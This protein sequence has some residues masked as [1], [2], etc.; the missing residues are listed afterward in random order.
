MTPGAYRRGAHRAVEPV[1]ARDGPVLRL[2]LDRPEQRNA[3]DDAMV[4]A[5]IAAFD[6][7]GRDDSVRAIVVARAVATTSAG[8]STSWPATPAARPRPSAGTIQRRLPGQAHRLIPLVLSVQVP[9]VCAVTG[10]AA[11][12]GFQLALAA[13][14]T[15]AAEDARFWEPFSARGFTPDSGATWLLPRLVG[16][17]RAREH[18]DARA[19]ALGDRGTAWGIVHRAVPPP[20]RPARSAELLSTLVDGPTVALGLTKWL[21]HAGSSA[22]LDEQLR[23]EGFALELSSRSE[24]FREG[25]AAF[26]GSDAPLPRFGGPLMGA[27]QRVV[28][29]SG[30]RDTRRQAGPQD[31]RVGATPRAG[32]LAGGGGRRG[33]GGDPLGA[34][35]RR[36]RGLVPGVRWFRSG[37]RHLAPRVRRARPDPRRG[38]GGGGRVVGLQPGPPQ[39][40]RAQPGRPGPL[41][42]RHRG[43][44]A[45]LPPAAGAQRGAVVPAVQRARRRVGPGLPGHPGRTGG[46]RL[47]GERAEGV[48]HLGP[49]LRVRRAAGPHGSRC[50]QTPGDHLLPAG[51]GPARGGGATAAPH[52]RG[53]RLQRGLLGPG[54]GPRRPA[55]RGGQ[56]R[57][58]GGQRHAVG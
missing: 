4:A 27:R 54:P 28:A 37:R 6:A 30:H 51:P 5:L 33:G 15:V 18:A 55:G 48:E 20:R 25:L 32:E 21:L 9:V 46:R 17:P 42:P 49:P 12:I 10:W 2:R 13:D 44:A 34:R 41:R 52:R 36:L 35:P 39:P 16:L 50:P 22:T 53:G 29:G 38:P 1:A 45:A 3:L 26:G 31:R 43:P 40:A 47:A 58:E 8:A 24:D 56:R 11:G 23:N 19:R 7:A 14:F 57:V